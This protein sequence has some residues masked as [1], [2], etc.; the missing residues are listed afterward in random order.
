[1]SIAGVKTAA[2]DG[3]L[4][5][6]AAQAEKVK[7]TKALAY[8]CCHIRGSWIISGCPK[9]VDHPGKPIGMILYQ[10]LVLPCEN[11][12]LFI[13]LSQSVL[14]H[15]MG[16]GIDL[17]FSATRSLIRETNL[18]FDKNLH[19][20]PELMEKTNNIWEQVASN[21]LICMEIHQS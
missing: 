15:A 21:E 7:K 14:K 13:E 9:I 19:S 5:D 10:K 3:W 12:P 11:N 2:Y 6:S 8:A 17:T 18:L 20:F 4:I 16:C 1:M